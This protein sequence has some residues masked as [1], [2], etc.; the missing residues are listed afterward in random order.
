MEEFSPVTDGG[1]SR[2]GESSGCVQNEG[3]VQREVI[4][5]AIPCPMGVPQEMVN[6]DN[7]IYMR[8]N[9]Q[10]NEEVIKNAG[11]V[12]DENAEMI[13]DENEV[14]IASGSEEVTI[15]TES[16]GTIAK[17]PIVDQRRRFR[18]QGEQVAKEIIT[19]QRRKYRSQ[20]EQ[21]SAPQPQPQPQQHVS[22]VPDLSLDLSPSES[23]GNVSPILDHVELPLAQCRGTRSNFGKPPLRY[24]FEHPSRDHDIANFISYS[25]LSHAYRAFVASLQTVP[26][27]RDWK[28]AKQDPNWNAAMKEEMHALQKN[29]TWELVLLPKGKKAVGCKWVFTMKQNPKGEVDRYKARL[30]AKRV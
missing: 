7:V 24:G 2:E 14:V 10:E 26:I 30:V 21:D 18:S 4:V 3:G 25:R 15:G 19:Y 20:G 23:S 6:Q 16:D 12:G 13:D 8:G 22:P 27:S 9:G 28:C 29:K 1:D 17:E 5:G 11:M